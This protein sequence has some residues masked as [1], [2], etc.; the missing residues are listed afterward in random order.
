M[1]F[2][3][4]SLYVVH[5][6]CK[7]PEKEWVIRLANL[8][9]KKIWW[10]YKF[11]WSGFEH[12]SEPFENTSVCH[13][14][15][16]FGPSWEGALGS[17]NR[18]HEDVLQRFQRAGCN[19][20][21]CSFE[22]GVFSSFAHFDRPWDSRWW[23]PSFFIFTAISQ[24]GNLPQIGVKLNN[25]WNHHLDK[26]ELSTLKKNTFPVPTLNLPNFRQTRQSEKFHSQKVP[27]VFNVKILGASPCHAPWKID[28]G[29]GMLGS[30]ISW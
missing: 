30:R 24:N 8:L 25:L 23:F 21:W 27:S 29:Q 12:F 6:S 15:A 10:P 18:R 26:F 19:S 14:A 13:G 22:S 3:S 9:L 28:T 7:G 16:V 4:D 20:S 11:V 1:D 17:T 2:P 5:F